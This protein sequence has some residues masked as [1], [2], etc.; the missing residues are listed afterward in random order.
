MGGSHGTIEFV[1]APESMHIA[2]A[3]CR[4]CGEARLTPIL[5]MGDMPLANRLLTHDQLHA[6]E[7]SYPLELVLCPKCALAQITDTVPPDQLIRNY[8]H[9]S[10]SSEGVLRHAR[11]LAGQII[12]AQKLRPTSLVIHIASN[13]GYLLKNY[14]QAGIP[15]LGIEP[16]L[17]I[18]EVARRE[19]NVPTLCKFFNKDLAAQLEG[20]GQQADVV[21][22]HNLLARVPDPNG[23]AAG[24]R[25]V[26][27]DSGVAVIEVPYVKDLV[28]HVEFDA[29]YHEH[30]C[31]FS[32]TSV[33][34]LLARH[35]LVIHDVE[36]VDVHGGSLQLFV[37]RSGQSSRRVQALLQEEQTWGV[38]RPEFYAS[39]MGR[40]ES[41][42][43]ELME[44]L[45][46][47]KADGRRIAVYG[48]SAS[49]NTLMNYFKI[50]S[51]MVDFVVDR[52]TCKQGRYTPGTHLKI[53]SPEKLVEDKPDYVLLLSWDFADEILAQQTIYRQRGGRFIIP[54]PH[55]KVA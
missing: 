23:F 48:A 47:L 35:A 39:L 11:R 52:N 33:S 36:R 38:E 4:S 31:Y 27:K 41:L 6:A 34:R 45:R 46:G 14:Q 2:H 26:L 12:A 16:A 5:A 37:G 22:V 7:P 8:A 51:D 15:V 19:H 17:H 55:L 28:D 54:L 32:L 9:F 20:C 3:T 43:R 21:H 29:I 42:R 18:A 40:V 10:S 53:H 30:L 24:L 50:G 13:D 25:I 44:M 49:G 1:G